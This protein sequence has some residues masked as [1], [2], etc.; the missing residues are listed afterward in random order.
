MNNEHII[1]ELI[2]NISKAETIEFPFP[3]KF[4][5]NIFPKDFYE[6]LLSFLPPKNTYLPIKATGRVNNVNYSNERYTFELTQDDYL[7]KLDLKN[8]NFF[9]NLRNILFSPLLFNSVAS[10]FKK[11]IDN[12][13]L[14]LS[15]EEKKT[16]SFPNL[17]FYFKSALIKDYTKYSLGAHTDS[18]HKF[19]TFLFYIPSN[20][21][22]I[23]NGTALYEPINEIKSESHFTLESTKKLF[24]KIKTCPFIPN[25]LLIFPRTNNS[26]HG[27]EEVNIEQKERNLLLLNYYLKKIS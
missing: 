3:H 18:F 1:K 17:Q 15:E 13:L 14:N 5:E 9:Y 21:S 11:T 22:L 12:H 4:I 20:K 27:V 25:S 23:K 8:R 7:S 26:F 2:N 10:S 6:E 19:I 16:I 24:N